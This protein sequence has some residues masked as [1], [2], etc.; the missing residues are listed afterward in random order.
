MKKIIFLLCLALTVL[1]ASAATLG[2]EFEIERADSFQQGATT[3][4][5]AKEQLGVPTSI[6]TDAEGNQTIWWKYVK[7]NLL[8]KD[9][10]KLAVV[11][12]KEGKMLRI[13]HR[14][15]IK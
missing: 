1:S 6:S 14:E 11:F 8:G 4:D 12:D 2:Q 5:E 7:V 10:R 13:A 9:I 15:V 3:F